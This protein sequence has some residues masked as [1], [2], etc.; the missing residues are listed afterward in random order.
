MVI[1][2]TRGE[3]NAPAWRRAMIRSAAKW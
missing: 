2:I 1:Y 3:V